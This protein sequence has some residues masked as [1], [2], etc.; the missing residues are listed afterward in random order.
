MFNPLSHIEY[1][2][3]DSFKVLT[4]GDYAERVNA[5]ADPTSYNIYIFHS[6][7]EKKLKQS[8]SGAER[9]KMAEEGHLVV[10]LHQTLVFTN[11]IKK[12]AC[13]LFH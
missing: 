4:R 6:K 9:E 8:L 1:L 2:D 12:K 3:L 7:I 13:V 10:V 11:K 5:N